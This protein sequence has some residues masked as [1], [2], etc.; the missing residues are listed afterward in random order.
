MDGVGRRGR[1]PD[2]R[3][4]DA[5]PP[6]FVLLGASTA[7]HR[8]PERGRV[9]A[10]HGPAGSCRPAGRGGDR[11]L[12]L[13]RSHHSQGSARRRRGAARD[14]AVAHPPWCWP[15]PSSPKRVWP[16][17]GWAARR[18]ANPSP[19][20]TPT[21]LAS[22]PKGSPHERE[23]V[24]TRPEPASTATQAHPGP[25]DP[26][27]RSGDPRRTG[28]DHGPGRRVCAP[29]PAW[30]ADCGAERAGARSDPRH[31]AS[32]GRNEPGNA[33]PGSSHRGVG[34]RAP[35]A[36]TGTPGRGV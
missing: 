4:G 26:G 22:S 12:G 17:T 24:R 34:P 36:L 21:W 13:S 18:R 30:G 20:P 15:A 28:N 23:A 1:G 27:P 35:D 5:K 25:P 31:G 33:Q 9:Q 7:R 2:G 6:P 8:S 32:R 10:V 3:G 29:G 11:R 19:P 14:R 16:A